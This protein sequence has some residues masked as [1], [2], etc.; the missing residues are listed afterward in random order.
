VRPDQHRPRDTGVVDLRGRVEREGVAREDDAERR[1]AGGRGALARPLDERA[2][3][4][5]RICP[6]QT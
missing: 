4:W 5:V 6:A 2:E 3:P 1:R